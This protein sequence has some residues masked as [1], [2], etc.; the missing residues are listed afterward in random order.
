MAGIV[1]CGQKSLME[2]RRNSDFYEIRSCAHGDNPI[3]ETVENEDRYQ[4]SVA[5]EAVKP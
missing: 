3:F 4:D 5:L 1:G 2:V